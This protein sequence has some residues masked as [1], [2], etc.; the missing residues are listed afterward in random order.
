[1]TNS[2]PDI[3]TLMEPV[4]R[5]FFGEPNK[6][7]SKKGKLRFGTHGSLAVDLE[8]GTWYD[9]ESEEGGG[10]LDLIEKMTGARGA[11][12]FDWLEERGWWTNGPTKSN[13]KDDF[14]IIA[15][16]PY[17]DK[18]G[19][20]LFEIVRLEPKDFR[21]RRPDG[22]GG[23]IWSTKGVRQVPY[24]LPE[25]IEAIA[26]GHQIIIVEGEKD[27]DNLWK[28]GI[29]ATCNAGG[30]NKWRDELNQY[31]TDA[32]AVIIAD[33]DPQATNKKGELLFHPDGRPRFPGQ[34][35]ANDVAAKLTG[36]AKRVRVLDLGKEW[37]ECP[38]KGDI[39]DWLA[40]GGT[41][42][43]FYQAIEDLPDWTPPQAPPGPQPGPGPKPKLIQS[44]ADF[45][46][47]FT[48]PDYLIDGV[49]QRRFLYSL[50]GRTGSGKTSIM[51]L[52]SA[53]VALGQHIGN[54]EV[55]QGRV[56]YCAGE[57]A[58]DVRMR[59]I[60]LATEMEF[61]I[62]RIDVHFVTERGNITKLR[63]R[64]DQ[65]LAQIGDVV[66]VVIDT[67]Q[68]Y[69]PGDDPNNNAQ[70][71]AYALQLRTLVNCPG[72]P[73]VVV[74]SHP[75]KRATQ[76]NLL[77]YGGGG[78][79]N[80]VDG[81]LT[82]WKDDQ[83]AELHW[84]GKFRGPDFAPVSFRLRETTHEKLIDRKG[85]SL[86]TVVASFL[87]DT[88]KQTL[89]NVARTDEDKVLLAIKVNASASYADLA[90]ICGW[91]TGAGDPYRMKA[92]RALDRLIEFKLIT[93]ERD[94]Y[95]FTKKGEAVVEKLTSGATP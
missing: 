72:G 59:W 2:N 73:A 49:L 10:V 1:L 42:K 6:Q 41:V 3:A 93:K 31:F 77:P 66:L 30:V 33:N 90:N 26:N 76:D 71:I 67:A 13:G 91:K 17:H 35:H 23:W 29:P 46:A 44:S 55:D 50:T 92:K 62:D 80:E 24:R 4:A 57:N 48:P 64:I 78:F 45:V 27:A 63:Q 22:H 8:K 84:Q 37:P 39:S 74:P 47:A 40:A 14:K 86:R 38:P 94:G 43:Q 25:V 61:D 53:S 65:E 15:T 75:I 12:R 88:D 85:R 18:N 34:D 87:S 81:N 52:L 89:E 7:L 9:H 28:L 54:L 60:A 79:V 16:Y 11:E 19:Q 21:Q 5:H 56:L 36:T 51:L 82:C 70:Q 68:A 32:D 20:L 69:F 95:A 83:I 58:D